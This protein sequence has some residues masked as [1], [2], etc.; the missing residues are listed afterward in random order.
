MPKIAS[1]ATWSAID[2]RTCAGTLRA[3]DRGAHRDVAEHREAAR[4]ELG[5]V[6]LG[7]LEH[8]DEL[9]VRGV[10]TRY[11]RST[12]ASSRASRS[13][14]SNSTFCLLLRQYARMYLKRRQPHT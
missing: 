8:P 5:L 10:A 4:D 6:G 7:D 9:V 12:E 1:V 11:A 3:D 13:R 14:R 2:R